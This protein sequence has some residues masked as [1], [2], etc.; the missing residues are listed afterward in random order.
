MRKQEAKLTERTDLTVFCRNLHE[1]KD[2]AQ[3]CE[4]IEQ[5][6]QIEG[7]DLLSVK[8][9]DTLDQKPA[10]RPFSRYPRAISELSTALRDKGGCPI[11][12]EVL[13]RLG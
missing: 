6:L 11:S 13:A 3:A 9:C 1:A 4:A 10:L 12:R 2:I 8:F 7:Y 5:N